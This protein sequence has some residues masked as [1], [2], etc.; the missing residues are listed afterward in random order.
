M[1]VC[2]LLFIHLALQ[3]PVVG[4]EPLELSSAHN[5]SGSYQTT[6]MSK[7]TSCADP[8][9]PEHTPEGVL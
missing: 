4:W 5:G 3:H 8:R 7:G 2:I 9:G 6:G 1:W